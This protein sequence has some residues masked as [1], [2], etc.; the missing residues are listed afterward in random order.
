MCIRKAS[1]FILF[2]TFALKLRGQLG[3]AAMSRTGRE[4]SHHVQLLEF[5]KFNNCVMLK[6]H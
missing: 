4:C 1:F 5:N 2:L 6:T 3:Q